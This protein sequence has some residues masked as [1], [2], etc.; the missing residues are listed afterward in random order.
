MDFIFYNLKS[1]PHLNRLIVKVVLKSVKCT[2]DEYK[3]IWKKTAL[4]ES[5]IEAL[6]ITDL[7]FDNASLTSIGN[8]SKV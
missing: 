1:N 8:I 4:P 7:N 6:F 3:K 2:L 5:G